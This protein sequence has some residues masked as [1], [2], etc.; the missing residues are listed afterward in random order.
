M[1]ESPARIT[2]VVGDS[3]WVVGVAP[4]SCGACGGKGC[5]SSLFA[6]ALHPDEPE[7]QVDNPIGAQPGE[8]VVVGLP[9]GAL[10]AAALA[11]YI[12]PLLL[13]LTGAAL[14]QYFAGELGAVTGGLCGLGLAALYLKRRDAPAAQPVV[15]RRGETTCASR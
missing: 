12:L 14:G 15:L 1:I 13:L 11:G 9:D 5:G 7:F 3:T 6:R 2:R 4:T 10:F 8:A